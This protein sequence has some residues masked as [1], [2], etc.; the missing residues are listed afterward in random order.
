[1][2][3]SKTA[4]L[5][6]AA[7]ALLAAALPALAY[8]DDKVPSRFDRLVRWDPPAASGIVAEAPEDLPGFAAEA[9]GW[10]AFRA[11]HGDGWAVHV[12]RR[13][14]APL[15]V[16]GP[17]LPWYDPE[18]AGATLPDL[19]QRARAFLAGNASLFK[20]DPSQLVLSATGSGATDPDRWILLFERRVDGIP[21]E[22]ARVRFFLNHGRLVAFGA[23]RWGGLAQAPRAA[24]SADVAR[25]LLFDYMGILPHDGVVELES[26]TTV[27]VPAA[28]AGTEYG[29]YTGLAGAGTRFHRAYVF[30]LEVAGERGRWVGKV[31]ASSGEILALYDTL[32]Y[33]QV[34]GG[35][36]P[37]SSD[38]HGDDGTEHPDYP[39][40]YVNLTVGGSPSSANDMGLFTCGGSGAPATTALAS[41]YVR[42]SD[43]CGAVNETTTCDSDLDLKIGPPG[44]T[45]C[46]VPSGDSVGD[47]HPARNAYYQVSRINERLRHW[48]PGNAWLN[49]QVEVDTNVNATCNASWGGTL[50]MYRAGGGCSNTGELAGVLTHEW[51]HGL[52]QND[53]G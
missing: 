3:E 53:G 4:V 48:L 47:T 43:S 23:D 49:G 46:A 51:G 18:G 13:S 37:I 50:N 22:G 17:G 16:E 7:A 10:A 30:T 38:G 28:A 27:L 52:D 34:K 21:V 40:P 1:M 24:I 14:G 15:L 5:T 6:C 20:I 45:N 32:R 12:D 11:S 9:A 31:D 35:I 8:R 19:E 36:Y 33:A 26:G 25:Q 2:L 44:Q 39:M 29:P 42:I 41:T